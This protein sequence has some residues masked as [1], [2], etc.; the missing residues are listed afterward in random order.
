MNVCVCVCLLLIPSTSATWHAPCGSTWHGTLHGVSWASGL[1]PPPLL[2]QLQTG[3]MFAAAARFPKAETEHT[4][5]KCMLST[6]PRVGH[7]SQALRPQAA[8][9]AIARRPGCQAPPHDTRTHSKPLPRL[10]NNC[11]RQRHP[12]RWVRLAS[13]LPHQPRLAW[14][15]VLVSTR[16][17]NTCDHNKH[18]QQRMSRLG[19]RRQCARLQGKAAAVR[20][21]GGIKGS[22]RAVAAHGHQAL[23]HQTEAGAVMWVLRQARTQRAREDGGG[24]GLMHAWHGDDVGREVCGCDRCKAHGCRRKHRDGV[25]LLGSPAPSSRTPAA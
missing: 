24:H 8:D 22:H 14:R 5:S 12:M 18:P 25:L 20:R 11:T 3:V 17:F 2:T 1:C 23:A 21:H 19:L 9:K 15:A 16:C 7:S 4:G 10:S 6:T 13:T